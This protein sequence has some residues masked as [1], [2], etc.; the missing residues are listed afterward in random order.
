MYNPPLGGY[1]DP[2]S[3]IS[4]NYLGL[5]HYPIFPILLCLRLYSNYEIRGVRTLAHRE[6]AVLKAYAL[7]SRS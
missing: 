1:C 5:V 6:R 2:D 4:I 7:Q 3:F